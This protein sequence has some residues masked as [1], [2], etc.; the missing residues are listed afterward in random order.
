MIKVSV[1]EDRTFI[2]IIGPAKY[3]K[4]MLTDLKGKQQYNNSSGL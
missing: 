1:Q 4:Q 2:N 3:I